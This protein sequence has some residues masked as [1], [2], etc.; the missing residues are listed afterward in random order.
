MLHRS[1]AY[2]TS[3]H[4]LADPSAAVGPRA[5]TAFGKRLCPAVALRAQP[6]LCV[7]RPAASGRAEGSGCSS[8]AAAQ[9]STRRPC[10]GAGP[11]VLARHAAQGLGAWCVSALAGLEPA[12]AA[13][14][15]E[16][17]NA[18]SLPT[19][20]IHVSSTVEWGVAMYLVWQYAEVT[21]GR[22]A[23][24]TF[25][26]PR[27]LCKLMQTVHSCASYHVIAWPRGTLWRSP[28]RLSFAAWLRRLQPCLSQ[29]LWHYS[30]ILDGKLDEP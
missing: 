10:R 15:A 12:V 4:T 23:F 26:C 3:L 24:A 21:G 16:P 2:C 7:C 5:A 19:W 22:P 8:G 11:A 28:V 9:H 17:A 25:P 29:V 27:Q 18:L 14:H 6:S 30:C 13:V 1:M 20:A